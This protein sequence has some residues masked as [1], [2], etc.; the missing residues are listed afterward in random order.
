MI[1][2]IPCETYYGEFRTRTFSDIFGDVNE[3]TEG[4]NS[5]QI[6]NKFKNTGTLLTL[7]YLLY[8]RYG[9]SHIA[10]SDENQFKY[11]L[12]STTFMYGPTWEKRLEIQESLRALTEDD[13]LRG[14]KAIYNHSFNPGTA[15]STNTLEELTTINEQNTTNYKKSKLEGYSILLS[16]LE[17]DVTEEFL[18]RFKKLFITVVAGDYPLLYVTEPEEN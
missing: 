10:S 16:L 15:P 11:A 13:I 14:G 8:S 4:Y 9:N 6:P 5:S 2:T 12:Y 3:F 7:Y 1:P 18:S 17:T